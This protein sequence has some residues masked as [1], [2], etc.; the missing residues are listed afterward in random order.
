M[1]D[2][3]L[4]QPNQYVRR[5]PEKNLLYRIIQEAWPKFHMLRDRNLPFFV[6][7][8]FY[9]F[10]ECGVLENGFV[11]IYCYDCPYSGVVAFS[12]LDPR[13]GLF[14]NKG[15]DEVFLFTDAEK[16]RLREN[17]DK[18]LFKNFKNN[19]KKRGF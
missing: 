10:L 11:R 7:D 5:I 15:R 6:Q 18:N 9:D 19:Q 1:P 3:K 12:R 4:I 8:E 17:S 14:Q 13:W 16:I 2:A